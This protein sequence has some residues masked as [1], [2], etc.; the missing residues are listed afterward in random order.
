M[1]A[2]QGGAFVDN[3]AYLKT[4]L[5]WLEKLLMVAV[6]RQQKE[7]KEVEKIARSKAD[8]ASSHWW[9]GIVSL[10]GQP[11]YDEYRKP[12][13][14]PQ[15]QPYHQQMEARIQAT[16]QRGVELG[17][18]LLRDR[19]QLTPFE[20]NLVLLSLA[21]EVNRRYAR[22]YRYLQNEEGV[23][24]S[25]LPTLDLA[26]RLLC[27]DDREWRTARTR[28]LSGS[29]LLQHNLLHLLPRPLDTTLN[30]YLQLSPPLLDY[31]LTEQPS[32]D[33]LETLLTQISPLVRP[34]ALVVDETPI[35]WEDLILPPSLLAKLKTL[36]RQHMSQ[37]T[38]ALF[39]GK[40]G[41]GKT[42]AALAIAHSLQQPLHRVDL[43]SIPPTDYSAL[44]QEIATRRPPVLL[45]QSAQ[46]WLRRSAILSPAAIHQFFAERHRQPSLTLLSLPLREAVAL[47]WQPYFGAV[48]EFAPPTESDRL[49]LWQ[50]AFPAEVPLAETFDWQALAKVRLTVGEIRMIAQSV[51]QQWSTTHQTALSL[52]EVQAA[53]ADY[54]QRWGKRVW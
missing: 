19:L 54:Q 2:E 6:A 41:T 25:D 45:I 50:R 20:K 16:R 38:I 13:V 14:P 22:L 30:H 10:E 9:K 32:A 42:T 26:L 24:H 34:T 23:L 11:A 39:A 52:S 47:H 53:I 5:N 43:A 18:P 1:V 51:F 27:R 36:E 40:P 29:P 35:A 46:N 49:Q 17:L 28:L 15:K 4:E 7:T 8:R 31:L 21:P 3:W 44:L 12:A 33:R 37:G 48:L